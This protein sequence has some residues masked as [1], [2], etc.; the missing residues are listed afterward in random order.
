MVSF[1]MKLN[2]ERINRYLKE[3]PVLVDILKIGDLK[4]FY[5]LLLAKE[6]TPDVIVGQ[7]TQL[8]YE[9]G[10][11][12][13]EKLDGK[14]PE[15]GFIYTTVQNIPDNIKSTIGP[16][17]FCSCYQLTEVIIPDGVTKICHSAF[18]NCKNL[19]KVLIPKS[20]T[21]IDTYAFRNCTNLREVILPEEFRREV[22]EF[23]RNE[24]FTNTEGI[25]F[26]F[27]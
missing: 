20:V 5:N 21:T 19:E 12:V 3:K 1:K 2:P 7:F 27:I 13:V 23:T 9:S 22:N 8:F 10:I 18:R 14:V 17:A 15:D 16:F 24:V 6:D 25:N 26:T 11:D 4:R